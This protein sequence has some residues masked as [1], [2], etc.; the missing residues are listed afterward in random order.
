MIAS[1]TLPTYVPILSDKRA[2]LYAL[3]SLSEEA[4]KGTRPLIQFRHPERPK[5]GSPKWTPMKI[6]LDHLQDPQHGLIGCW[7]STQ[8]ILVDLRDLQLMEF[9]EPPLN[10]IFDW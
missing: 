9:E 3:A 10:T 4:H 6:L 2:E 8:P 5:Q 1:G 7:G